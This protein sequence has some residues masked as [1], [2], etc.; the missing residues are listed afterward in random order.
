[1]SLSSWK[2]RAGLPA[3]LLIV[4]L[5]APVAPADDV[6]GGG[7]NAA[8]VI[9]TLNAVQ[10]PGKKFRIY[11]TVRDETPGSCG[12]VVTG[13]AGGTVLCDSTGAFTGD[14]DVAAP[15]QITAVA[16]DGQLSSA[17]ATLT[18]AN[19]APTTTVR[20]R[21]LGNNFTFSGTVTDEAPAGLTVTLSGFTGLNGTT[22]TVTANGTWSVTVTL[23]QF[24]SGTA[25]AKVTDWYG[26]TGQASTPFGG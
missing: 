21:R 25:T 26:L 6:A 4:L 14:F 9:L 7:A 8:P 12:V 24:A 13:A 10:I 3:G 18:L 1:M 2:V 20:C 16:G 11:G 19:N 23:S 15:G 22:A 17:P 5:G